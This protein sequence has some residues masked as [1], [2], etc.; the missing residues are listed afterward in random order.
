VAITY[1]KGL[2]DYDKISGAGGSNVAVVGI[3]VQFIHTRRT[4]CNAHQSC[5]SICEILSGPTDANRRDHA[6][7]SRA[8]MAHWSTSRKAK[9]LNVLRHGRGLVR[10]KSGEWRTGLGLLNAGG[11]GA[12]GLPPRK[13]FLLK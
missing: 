1:G 6:P 11:A 13:V 12:L 3:D 8:W 2:D 4:P 10:Q 5:T 9:L 7:K